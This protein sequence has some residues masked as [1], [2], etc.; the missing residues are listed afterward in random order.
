MP[1]PLERLRSLDSCTVSDALDRL[2]L[3]TVVSNVPQQSGDGRIAGR[4]IT[5]KLGVGEPASPPRHLCTAAI[6]RG[7]PDNVIVVEQR[8][9]IDAGSWGGLLTLGATAKKIP[10]VVLDG[11]V[12]DID[13]ARA[14]GFPVF[15]RSTTLRTA[16]RRIIEIATDV[17]VQFETAE[18]EPGDY[19]LADRSG[20]AFIKPQDLEAVLATAEQIV[21]AEQ[22]MARAIER[23]VPIGDV[24]AAR[25]ETMVDRK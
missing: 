6:E 4:A 19:V 17:P 15:C 14:L 8:T 25:Y 13:E 20:I 18:V 9:G 22:E 21:A 12:R 24:M 1:D 10:G 11:P 7:G 3:G 2:G 23:G 16:R 5:V